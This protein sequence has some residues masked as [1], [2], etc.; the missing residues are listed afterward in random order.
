MLYL[1]FTVEKDD[2]FITDVDRLML[3]E[4]QIHDFMYTLVENG[5]TIESMSVSDK[6]YNEN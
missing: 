5:F 3:S 1:S 4:N 6:P 2:V